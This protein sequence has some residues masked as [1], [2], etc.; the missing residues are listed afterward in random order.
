MQ[1]NS[2]SVTVV[3]GFYSSSQDPEFDHHP[4][5]N[6]SL[7]SESEQHRFDE[8]YFE[9]PSML[10]QNTSIYHSMNMSRSMFPDNHL[11][12]NAHS[13]QNMD[14]KQLNDDSTMHSQH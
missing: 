8:I 5:D 7:S 13:K 6:S 9:Q 2:S 12:K 14:S 1:S 11:F 4:Q 10:D 3:P